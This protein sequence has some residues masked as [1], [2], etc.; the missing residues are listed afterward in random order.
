[1]KNKASQNKKELSWIVL[2]PSLLVIMVSSISLVDALGKNK[3]WADDFGNISAFNQNLGS[4]NDLSVNSG[5]FILNLFFFIMGTSF[6]VGSSTPYL[7]SAS[8]ISG[9]GIFLIL[10]ESVKLKLVSQKMAI[11]I[12]ACLMGSVTLWPVF[13]WS[14]NVTHGAS[15]FCFG[16][17]LYNF[18]TN[19][20]M[21]FKSFKKTIAENIWLSLIILCNP[22]YIGVIVI[23]T[24]FSMYM[25]S[26][27]LGK[28]AQLSRRTQFLSILIGVVIPLFYFFAV[29]QPVQSNN[30]SYTNTS[31]KNIL[32]NLNFYFGSFLNIPLLA[33]ILISIG[34][35]LVV[36][37]RGYKRHELILIVSSLSILF[38]VLIQSQVRVLNYLIFPIIF[39]GLFFSRIFDRA[40]ESNSVR[41]FF[42]YFFIMSLPLF[43]FYEARY[44]RAWYQV[45]GLGA[46]TDQLLE[47]IHA[48]V[49]LHSDLCIKFDLSSQDA[50]YL[51]GGFSGT[52]AF[53][54]SP[55]YAGKTFI[56]SYNTCVNDKALRQ[57]VIFK[58]KNG[59]FDASLEEL[60]P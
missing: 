7:I 41:R 19:W 57:I 36:S 29:S 31:I 34:V 13:L 39:L 6:G 50:N 26:Y 55:N 23:Y 47:E 45:P 15:L 4:I 48:K 49:P 17:A 9:F 25:K 56:D 2:L 18:R 1:M 5:R 27:M 44:T 53:S 35:L 22:L 3:F 33:L 54:L 12:L 32:P 30:V 43:A 16:L 51:I 40:L 28:T 58:S 21:N 38:P 24:I 60:I 14:T 52:K 10:Y 8:L 59:K 11:F 46:E 20:E 42:V 37:V